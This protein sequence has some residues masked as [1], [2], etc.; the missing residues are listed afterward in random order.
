MGYSWIVLGVEIEWRAISNLFYH[1]GVTCKKKFKTGG[2]RDMQECVAV[3]V[4]WPCWWNMKLKSFR[5]GGKGIDC[6]QFLAG[7]S[8]SLLYRLVVQLLNQY[9]KRGSPFLNWK[10]NSHTLSLHLIWYFE[11]KNSA[12]AFGSL[13][14]PS[15]AGKDTWPPEKTR[16]SSFSLVFPTGYWPLIMLTAGL[17]QKTCCLSLFWHLCLSSCMAQARVACRLGVGLHCSLWASSHPFFEPP[18]GFLCLTLKL[19]TRR[20]NFPDNIQKQFCIKVMLMLLPPKIMALHR[21][22]LL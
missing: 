4:Y 20:Q 6:F 8:I 16:I 13:C 12:T 9:T 1:S 2:R 7:H 22:L 19:H 18:H 3:T 21:D 5:Q 15:R 14:F 10:N 17:L 11:Q